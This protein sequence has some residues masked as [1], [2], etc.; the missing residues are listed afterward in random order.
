MTESIE[1]NTNGL[2]ELIHAMVEQCP[3]LE[4]MYIIYNLLITL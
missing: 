4:I 1:H 2:D 3:A